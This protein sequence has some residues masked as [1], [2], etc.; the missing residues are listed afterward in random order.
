M[1][2][3]RFCVLFSTS[4]IDVSVCLLPALCCA[5]RLL[6][7][8]L[9]T[10]QRERQRR[11]GTAAE[12]NTMCILP[13]QLWAVWRSTSWLAPAVL[14]MG[15]LHVLLCEL[16]FCQHNHG[17]ACAVLSSPTEVLEIPCVRQLMQ[18]PIVARGVCQCSKP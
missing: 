10:A 1:V 16:L 14:K 4:D 15:V 3:M 5:V 12:L 17:C 6:R 11:S 7:V 13:A 2:E 18:S 9:A 8:S